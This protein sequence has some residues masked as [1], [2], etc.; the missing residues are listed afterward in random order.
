MNLFHIDKASSSKLVK[1]SGQGRPPVAMASRSTGDGESRANS[2][3]SSRTGHGANRDSSTG[4]VVHIPSATC[5]EPARLSVETFS[6]LDCPG[7]QK[8]RLITAS[9]KINAMSA[10]M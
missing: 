5:D 6:D 9:L 1:Q 10:E 7:P 2:E 3:N 8:K 4:A